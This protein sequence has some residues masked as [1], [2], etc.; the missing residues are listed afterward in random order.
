L[1]RLNDVGVAGDD[2]GL[3]VVDR[4]V[5]DLERRLRGRQRVF[6]GEPTGGKEAEEGAK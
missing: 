4:R 6:G 5:V 1:N 2:G 3:T